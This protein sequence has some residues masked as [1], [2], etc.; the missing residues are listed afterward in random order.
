MNEIQQKAERLQQENEILKT[1][2]AAL[3][4]H[5]AQLMA[6]YAAIINSNAWRFTWPVR[7]AVSKT[8][9]VIHRLALRLRLW[10]RPQE[11]ERQAIDGPAWNWSRVRPARTAGRET[12]AVHLHLYY[13]DLLPEFFRFFQNIPF[14]FDLYVS[15]QKGADLRAI[16]RQFKKL[17]YARSV[18]VKETENRGRD[19]APLYVLF[20]EEIARHTIF[21][22]VHSKKSLFTGSE[23]T[24]WRTQ[25]L[26]A[27]CGSEEQVRRIMGLL[28]STRNVGLLFPETISSMN[29]IAHSWLRNAA[30][31]RRLGR[32]LGYPFEDGLFNYPVG[33]FFWARTDALRPVFD[34]GFTYQDF[35]EEAGQIDGTLAHALERA[36]AFVARSRGY[37]LG[38]LDSRGDA[39]RFDRSDKLYQP[40]YNQSVKTARQFLRRFDAV[41]FDVFDTLITRRVYQPDDLFKMMDQRLRAGEAAGGPDRPE[42]LVFRKKAEQLAWEKHGAYTTIDAIYAEL[43][44]VMGI[45]AEKAEELK[46]LELDLEYELCIPRRDVLEIFRFLRQMEIPIYLVSDMYLPASQITRM[47]HKCGYD[48]FSEIILSCETGLRKDDGSMWKVLAEKWKG[49]RVVHVGDNLCSDIQLAGDY[50]IQTFTVLNPRDLLKLSPLYSGLTEC[51]RAGNLSSVYVMGRLVNEFLCNSPF[52]LQ[53][54][55]QFRR[56]EKETAAQA[57]F[58]PLLTVFAQAIP[59][60]VR[61]DQKLLF[62]S[63]E[64]YFL[65]KLYR[66][67]EKAAGNRENRNVYFLA[68]RCATGGATVRTEADIREIFAGNYHGTLKMLLE[69]RLG[70]EADGCAD[71]VV[72]LPEQLDEV[73]GYIRPYLKQILRSAAEDRKNYLGYCE[74]LGLLDDG[75]QPPVVVDLGYSGTIQ[76]HLSNLLGREVDGYYLLMQDEKKPKAFGN[77]CAGLFDC[78]LDEAGQALLERALYL[79]ALLQAPYGQLIRFEPD[80]E[81]RQPQPCYRSEPPVPRPVFFM[82]DQVLEYAREYAEFERMCGRRQTIDHYLAARIFLLLQQKNMLPKELL[83]SLSVEDCFCGAELRIVDAQTGKWSV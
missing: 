44:Q 6:A 62:L 53:E 70:F 20:G 55:G 14:P 39:V 40:Y 57:M 80:P 17:P 56:L 50:G 76:M 47:L 26:Q 37:A 2:N 1:E 63:R 52:A 58:A 10:P 3:R 38:I 67:Y 23:Q 28:Q 24:E 54:G 60:N 43:P 78:G 33:S 46:K 75:E 35:P 9:A 69:G 25:A 49:R 29:M 13:V 77:A 8:R 34:R 65:Q 11:P 83:S 30:D 81:T 4:E 71:I 15:C 16:Q 79:E 5:E 72:T 22:H 27:L 18:T 74:G 32:E 36:I 21:L 42:Y 19:L 41:S 12:I 31:G 45:T 64:G 66:E 61:P 59:Q 7:Y 82:Q 68:S 51:Y 48:G 73:M